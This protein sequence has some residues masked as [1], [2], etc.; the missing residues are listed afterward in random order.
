MPE[1][2]L[3][4]A[5]QTVATSATTANRTVNTRAFRTQAM[6]GWAAYEDTVHGF[7][8]SGHNAPAQSITI[9]AGTSVTDIGC[10][11]HGKSS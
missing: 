3:A 4:W 11:G 7:L 10:G 2:Q 1:S 6:T 5:C 8:C 9:R